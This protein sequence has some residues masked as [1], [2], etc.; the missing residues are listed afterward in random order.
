MAT[1]TLHC[2][3]ARSGSLVAANQERLVSYQIG[4]TLYPY[5]QIP[6]SVVADLAHVARESFFHQ[7]RG[8]IQFCPDLQILAAL[9]HTG[10]VLQ[11]P[12]RNVLLQLFH[13]VSYT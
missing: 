13:P 5:L 3:P 12:K 9:S 1:D 8:R 11:P 6:G 2:S 7:Y 10:E 4:R